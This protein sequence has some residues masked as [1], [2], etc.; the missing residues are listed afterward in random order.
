M[1]RDTVRLY[2]TKSADP[3]CEDPRGGGSHLRGEGGV[4]LG[5]WWET[6]Y[7]CAQMRFTASGADNALGRGMLICHMTEKSL[8]SGGYLVTEM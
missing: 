2:L 8:L 6:F 4:S 5:G 7:F 1:F 3:A